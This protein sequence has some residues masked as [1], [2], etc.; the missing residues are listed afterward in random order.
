SPTPTE[1]RKIPLDALLEKIEKR[2]ILLALHRTKGQKAEAAELL[3]IWRAR[4]F[5]RLEALQIRDDDWRTI[6]PGAPSDAP[7]A[8]RSVR[9]CQP[10][11]PAAARDR[12][13]PRLVAARIAANAGLHETAARRRTL[14]ARP[15]R[16]PRFAAR[17]VVFG[18]RSFA[19]SRRSCNCCW[20]YR[21]SSA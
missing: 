11:R 15:A 10:A 3:G 21:E 13:S 14:G 5:R 20:Q 17:T 18:Q 16:G 1:D 12:D 2:L 8:D 6:A 9:E 4:L 19:T 7:P